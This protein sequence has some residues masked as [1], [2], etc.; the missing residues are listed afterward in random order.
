MMYLYETA[1]ADKDHAAQRAERVAQREAQV[2][3]Y[4]PH[5]P[6]PLCLVEAK[7]IHTCDELKVHLPHDTTSYTVLHTLN[8]RQ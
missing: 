7:R 4:S 8:D 3:S 5:S 1:Q 6:L 2:V